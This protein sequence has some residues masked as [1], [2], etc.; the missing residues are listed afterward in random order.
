M[1]THPNNKHL[2]NFQESTRLLTFF[3]I[4]ATLIIAMLNDSLSIRCWWNEAVIEQ[5]RRNSASLKINHWTTSPI[6]FL[7]LQKHLIPLLRKRKHKRERRHFKIPFIS[8]SH[9]YRFPYDKL[10]VRERYFSSTYLG[11]SIKG[12]IQNNRHLTRD[13]TRTVYCCF[14]KPTLKRA[15]VKVL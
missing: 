14:A 6:N 9:A 2:Y 12:Q 3:R 13:I 1:E 7:G 15:I 5:V 4:P 11:Y 8:V 10:I